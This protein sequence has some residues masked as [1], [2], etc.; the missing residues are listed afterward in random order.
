MGRER[1]RE[2]EKEGE[3]RVFEFLRSSR[4][5]GS[6]VSDFA[7]QWLCATE[8]ADGM[9]NSGIPEYRFSFDAGCG[10]IFGNGYLILDG[11]I[12]ENLMSF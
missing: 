4:K 10:E 12:F 8:R 1:E 11:L 6:L 9:K 3:E 7:V 2:R 5:R